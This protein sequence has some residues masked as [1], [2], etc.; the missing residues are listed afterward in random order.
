[1]PKGEPERGQHN[2][3]IVREARL[4]HYF[5]GRPLCG[6]PDTL[7][8]HEALGRVLFGDGAPKN[9]YEWLGG[10]Q[11]D[12]TTVLGQ[13]HL[14]S[15]RAQGRIPEDVEVTEPFRLSDFPPVKKRGR[16]NE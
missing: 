12:P 1:M 9:L 15:F 14:K 4:L 10:T 3:G 6:P 7:E 2:G 5:M 13:L 11:Y 8:Q 16:R